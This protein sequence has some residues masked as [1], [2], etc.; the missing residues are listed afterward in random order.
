MRMRLLM[1]MGRPA[2]KSATPAV[3]LPH[4]IALHHGDYP[5]RTDS[6]GDKFLQC[7]VER[8][9]TAR[10]RPLSIF[11]GRHGSPGRQDRSKSHHHQG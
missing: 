3:Y 9:I 11:D 6:H 4:L 5:R 1:P 7:T 8:R 10:G 2:L